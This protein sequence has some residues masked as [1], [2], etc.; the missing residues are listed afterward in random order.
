MGRRGGSRSQ[1]QQR[2]SILGQ[3]SLDRR[4]CLRS[5]LVAVVATPDESGT[6]RRAV[7]D[8]KCPGEPPLLGNRV[9]IVNESR[10]TRCVY[11]KNASG[12]CQ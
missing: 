5:I 8:R 9:I 4:P 1:N 2:S 12:K 3:C 6:W 11:F 10:A 7:D